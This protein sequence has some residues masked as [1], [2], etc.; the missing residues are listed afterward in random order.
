MDWLIEVHSVFRWVVLLVAVAAIALAIL[1]ALGRREWDGL[2]DRTA[3]FFT[4]AMDIQLLIGLVLWLV[5]SRWSSSDPALTW[6]HPLAMLAA[7]GLAHVGRV[8]SDRATASAERGRQ[9]AIFFVASLLV[10]I[11]AIPLYAWPL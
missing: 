4:L 1:S 6:L 7:V 2:I 5:E 11:I 3:F 10:I 8:R 9:A